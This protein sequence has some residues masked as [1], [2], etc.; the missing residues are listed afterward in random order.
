MAITKA[1]LAAA[2]LRKLADALDKEP[3]L[4]VPQPSINFYC[5]FTPKAK[6]YFLD[7]A[8][9]LPRPLAKVYR[10]DSI[11]IEYNAD[12]LSVYA[13]I[14]RNALCVLKSPAIPAQ[15]ECEPVLSQAQEDSLT[16]V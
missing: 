6:Q 16:Q 5:W 14:E 3:E 1:G 11:Q 12:A 13:M 8:R 4:E 10:D 9:V 7:L 15:W 2:E